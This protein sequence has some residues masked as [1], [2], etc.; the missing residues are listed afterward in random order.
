MLASIGEAAP[1]SQI[2][3]IGDNG[4]PLSNF[5]ATLKKGEMLA[6]A[7]D[8]SGDGMV[9]R[10]GI[11][12]QSVPG[13]PIAPVGVHFTT[14]KLGHPLRAGYYEN[15]QDYSKERE[16]QAG[17]SFYS[18]YAMCNL[19][20]GNFTIM[21]AEFDYSGEQPRVVSFAARFDYGCE[22]ERPFLH[23]T[24]YYNS[25][26]SRFSLTAAPGAQQVRMGE[27]GKFLVQSER[28]SDLNLPI[29]YQVEVSPREESLRVE[30]AQ[31]TANAGESVEMT[32]KTSAAT[33]NRDYTITITGT[34]GEHVEKLSA[35]VYVMA[36]TQISI[37]DEGGYIGGDNNYLLK[38]GRLGVRV[39][40]LAGDGKAD[41]I[42]VS[43]RSEAE[44]QNWSLVFSSKKLGVSL[45]PGFYGNAERWPFEA[46]ARPGIDI[47]ANGRGCNNVTGNFTILDLNVDYSGIIPRVVSFAAKFEQHC[48]GG[49]SALTGTIYYNSKASIG[50]SLSIS[51]ATRQ[52]LAHGSATYNIKLRGDQGFNELVSLDVTLG[53]KLKSTLSSPILRPG[54]TA[55]LTVETKPTTR[56][57]D[58]QL[59]VAGIVGRRNVDTAA[60]VLAFH[61]P[62]S[63]ELKV[64]PG[65]RALAAGETTRVAVVTRDINYFKLP[66]RLTTEVMPANE[67]ISVQ[68]SDSALPAGEFTGMNVQVSPQAPP[69]TYTVRI[70]ASAGDI[71]RTSNL[72]VKVKKR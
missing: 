23:G 39:L 64:E 62:S 20:S 40:D 13:D 33:P 5:N 1:V 21:E 50:Y 51:P 24:I 65:K 31:T 46:A 9:D 42:A 52:L 11:S 61:P 48:E 43:Y 37:H 18:G 68:L 22:G 10:V 57:Y 19:V 25:E 69:G 17:L 66:I 27:S 3:L 67:H 4:S 49:S 70:T 36:K 63:F 60:A 16:G 12:Y 59:V 38:Y 45:E 26:I 55:T 8:D 7:F 2:T 58:Y 71:V 14:T 28:L 41:G 72:K 30:L 6:A 47:N 15:V 35:K 53:G 32:V 29:S 56:P 34:A 44:Q 54:E